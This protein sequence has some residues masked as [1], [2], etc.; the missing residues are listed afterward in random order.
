VD[1]VLVTPADHVSFTMTRLDAVRQ[2]LATEFPAGQI[3][4]SPRVAYGDSVAVDTRG[5][6]VAVS[7]DPGKHPFSSTG[8]FVFSSAYLREWLKSHHEGLPN[9]DFYRDLFMPV[10]AAGQCLGI[11]QSPRYWDDVGTPERYW[12][13][14]MLLASGRPV[15]SGQARPADRSLL[16]RCIVIGDGDLRGRTF[17]DSIISWNAEGALQVTQL[18]IGARSTGLEPGD[19]GKPLVSW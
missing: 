18:T 2:L 13:N 9:V 8:I 1:A 19:H 11:R 6:I 16:T 14:A 10:C 15:Y 17:T 7:P 4:V 5:R 12:L 3:V